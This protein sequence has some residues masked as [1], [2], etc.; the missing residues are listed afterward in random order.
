MLPL[1]KAIIS[2]D[3]LQ[4]FPTRQEAATGATA[5]LRQPDL[6]PVVA[7]S[8]DHLLGTAT[9]PTRW[10]LVRYGTVMAVTKEEYTAAYASLA[11]RSARG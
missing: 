6:T 4:V 2:K 11:E 8:D 5:I 7:P 9:P 3:L 1:T 10:Y